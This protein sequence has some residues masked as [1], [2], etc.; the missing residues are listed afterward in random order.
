MELS[1]ERN[2]R[3]G[4][5]MPATPFGPPVRSKGLLMRPIRTISPTPMVTMHR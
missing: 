4:D 2:P 3:V 5:W 1:R